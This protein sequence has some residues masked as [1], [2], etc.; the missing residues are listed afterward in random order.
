MSK[1]RDE[2]TLLR[3]NPPLSLAS[4]P[5]THIE[6]R[7]SKHDVPSRLIFSNPTIWPACPFVQH[8]SVTNTCR[9][10]VRAAI[11]IRVAFSSRVL[12]SQILEPSSLACVALVVRTHR[13]LASGSWAVGLQVYILY[14]SVVFLLFNFPS[15]CQRI[16][17]SSLK[18]T[19]SGIVW[20]RFL[21]KYP[22]TVEMLPLSP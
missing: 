17:G 6:K 14:V 21:S 9:C 18:R 7:L 12:T 8:F 16:K 19:Y 20:A 2:S 1:S 5:P 13:F 22:A 4:A 3:C 11:M 10:R 15:P